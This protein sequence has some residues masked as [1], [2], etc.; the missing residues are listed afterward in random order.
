[1]EL[2]LCNVVNASPIWEPWRMD[3]NAVGTENVSFLSESLTESDSQGGYSH[4][5]PL[6]ARLTE[7]SSWGHSTIS[8]S[9]IGGCTVFWRMALPPRRV[10][11]LSRLHEADRVPGLYQ[12]PE[13]H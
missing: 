6:D 4:S 5:H 8:W 12:D 2:L 7:S 11:P 9:L 3:L 13:E 10:S 1:M